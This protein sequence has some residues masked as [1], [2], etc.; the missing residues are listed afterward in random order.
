M[1]PLS[2]GLQAQTRKARCRVCLQMAA[3][4]GAA[5]LFAF[6]Q[7]AF[8]EKTPVFT[9]GSFID[10]NGLFIETLDRTEVE[11]LENGVSRKLEYMARDEIP[12]AYAILFEYPM[13]SESADEIRID[14]RYLSNQ[15]R[16]RD[17][18]Y[19]LI[20][21]LLGR[22]TIM[23]ASYDRQLLVAQD[24]VSDGFT[25]KNAVQQ[26]RGPRHAGESYLYGALFSAVRML[27]ERPE[28]RRVLIVFLETI[29]ADTA[30]KVKPLKN[31]FAATN[32]ELFI[33]NFSSQ[34]AS[35]RRGSILPSLCFAT[36]HDLTSVTS[37][38]TFKAS[39]YS[40]H[41]DDL[42]RRMI[43]QLRTLYTFG[44][45]A[46]SDADKPGSLEM[47]C[48]RPGSKVTHHPVVPVLR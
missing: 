17:V 37:G 34:L 3:F 27:N 4:L 23:I 42:V 18:A 47:R 33:V 13:L 12:V 43:N 48:T 44:I 2:S 11:V 29:D 26:L 41:A 19:E 7:G 14:P 39:D 9:T 32:I 28:K 15:T 25:A 10:K 31:L 38:E 20:D 16:A 40:G 35:D 22:Q 30:G 24:F 6:P 8:A 45:E 46:E 5:I 21:K 1:K 36:A